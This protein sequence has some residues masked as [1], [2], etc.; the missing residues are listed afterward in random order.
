MHSRFVSLLAFLALALSLHAAP[1]S[2]TKSIGPTGSYASVTAAI[3]DVQAQTLGGALVLELQGTYVSTVETFPLT[4]PSLN[5][6]S[7]VN[8]ITIRPASGATALSISSANTSAATVDLN[9]AQFVTIDGRPGGTGTAKQLTIAN[10]STLG[11]ALRFINEARGNTVRHA[12]LRGVNT[13]ATGGVIIFSTTTGT[14]G[15][16]SNNLDSCD[17]RDGASMPANGIYAL[18][19]TGTTAQNNSSNTVSNC[20]IF[21]FYSGSVDAAGVRLDGGNTDWTLTGN[22]F[23]QNASRAAA[24]TV[25]RPI[26]LNNTSGN[27]FTVTGNFIGGSTPTAGGTAWTTTGTAAT[28]RFGGIQLGVG[29]TTPTSV[30]GNTIQNIVWTSSGGAGAPMWSGIWLVAGSANLGAVTG[31]TIGSGTGTGSVSITTSGTGATTYGIRSSSSG[32]AVIANNSIGSI[33]ANGTAA[34]VS[35]SLVGIEVVNG[36]NTIT[37]NTVGSLTTANSLNA[38]TS[39]TSATAQQVAGI[40]ATSASITGNTVANL[41]SNYVGNALGGQLRGI[42]TTAGANTVTGNTVRNLS[43]TSQSASTVYGINQT[44]A[45]AGQTVSQNIVHSLADTAASAQVVVI[46]VSFSGST[47]GANVIARNLVHSLAVSS[48]NQSSGVYGMLFGTGTFTAENNFV[49]IGL[50]AGGNSTAGAS[51]V[52]GISDVATTPGRNFY[53]NSVYVG[54][55]QTSGSTDTFAFNSSGVTNARAFQNNIF[56]NAR[57][58]SGGI[59]KHYAVLYTSTSPNPAGLTAGGNIFFA[60]GTGGVLGR[61]SGTFNVDC[62]TLAAW[63]TATGQDTTSYHVDP[64]FLY[65]TGTSATVD[66]HLQSVNPAEAHGEAL[67]AVTDDFDGQTRSSLTPADIGADAGNFTWIEGLAPAVSYPLLTSGS[68]ANRTLTGWASIADNVGVS[69]GANAPRLYY[70]KSGDADVFGVANDATGNG[71]KSVPATSSSSPYSFTIDH[72]LLNGGGATV[73][74]TIQYFVVAQ[75]AANNLGSNPVGAAA[76]ANPPVQ[77]VSAKPSTGVNSYSIV[78]PLIGGTKTVGIGGDYPS[79]SGAGGLFAALNGS[80]LTGP[81][82]INITSDL[83]EDGSVRLNEFPSNDYPL[84]TVTIQPASAAMRTISGTAPSGLITLNGADRVTIDGRSGGTSRY[85]TFRNSSTASTASTILFVNDASSNT[86]R[87]SIVEGASTGSLY[88][89]IGVIAF[90]TGAVTGNDNNLVTDCQVRDLSSVAGVPQILIGSAGSSLA[91]SNSGNTISNNDLFNFD[92]VGIYTDPVGS[93]SWTISGNNIYEV[94][95]GI[96]N[97]YGIEFWGTGTNVITGNSIHDLLTNTTVSVG[98]YF[99]GTSTTTISRNRITAFAVNAVTTRVWGILASGRN[100]STLNVVNN[101]ITLSPVT[102]ASRNLYGVWDECATGSVVNISFNSIV[103]GGTESGTRSSWASFR[104]AASTHTA[105]DNLFLNLR[106]GGGVSHFAAGSEVTG[107]SYTASHNV[108]AG[109]GATAANFMDFSGTSGTAVPM[110]F[111]TWQSSTGDTASQAGIAGTGNFTTAMFANAAT[112]DLH[113]IPGG[114]VL[115]NNTGTP[116]A[117]VTTDFD[118]QLRSATL[119]YIGADELL[120]PFQ[121][122]ATDNGLPLNPAA[123]GGVNLLNFA[124]GL[125]AD[126]SSTGV[127]TVVGGVITL[128]GTPTVV[129]TGTPNGVNFTALFGRRKNSGLTYTVQ[130]STDLFTW[131]NNT[132]PPVVLADDGLIEACTVPYPFFLSDGQ[133]ARFFRV[134]VQ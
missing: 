73:G 127:I 102:S 18:G 27:N 132:V 51:H 101:Q 40:L 120:T 125:N 130:F 93:D 3:A 64:R 107:G 23:Y 124:F 56:V 115:V 24:A 60:L 6:A 17:I 45:S 95:P 31:N 55:T 105:R 85:L 29:S 121:Q 59:G 81:L 82:V 28:Y 104:S 96:S 109:T 119:P 110:S 71:W 113:L 37:N 128:R 108:Y 112:G 16:D 9:G 25:V 58:T 12:A 61:S 34:S 13:S 65:P 8:T 74:D 32:T 1:L 77:N 35:A 20:N 98:I 103:L 62:T 129:L 106:T 97:V 131:E 70:K 111:A 50:D 10:T 67:A 44:S 4:I 54:G 86:V 33:T 19:S 38:A 5:G 48:T 53:H 80:V 69:S 117:G 79:L 72:A 83:T 116:I 133:K 57:G 63:Q 22:S 11:V 134:A 91:V 52:R 87:S 88:A 41:N 75:D 26:C 78:G 7:A 90:T 84:A 49:R 47:S 118:G 92:L 2:G 39:S 36:G 14:N 114:N 76:S 100:G 43:T 21:N 89:A 30:N 15:N 94:N 123:N 99:F 42:V 66:L 122:W 46:G 126:G 68:P